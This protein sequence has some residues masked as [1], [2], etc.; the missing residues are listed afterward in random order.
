VADADSVIRVSI[1]GDA[2]NLSRAL[3]DASASIG[4]IA[5]GVVAG[6]VTL[7]T[8]EKGFDFLQDSEKE[9]ARLADA[10]K[11][12]DL[13]IGGVDERKIAAVA[14]SFHALGLS[15]QDVLEMSAN[16]AD[17]GVQAGIAKD[18]IAELAPEVAATAAAI[19]LLDDS[20]PAGNIDLIGKAAGGSAKAMKALGIS[21]SETDVVAR[22]MATGSHKLGDGLTD[23]E[24][25]TARLNFV[26]EALNPKLGA[27][28]DGSSD[29]E[30]S[31]RELTA[32]VKEL[33]GELGGPLS[34]ALNQVLRFILDEVRA[35]PGAVQGWESLGAAVEG[36]ART[37]VG[38][39]GNVADILRNINILLHQATGNA[40]GGINVGRLPGPSTRTSDNSVTRS[41]QRTT[42][43]NGG[44]GSSL[45]GP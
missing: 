18:R 22:A 24:I 8:I 44:I 28:T 43:R 36:F 25:K 17:F 10:I 35:I 45:G 3:K 1:I 26:L 32:T 4:G 7:R 11:R 39:L 16:F 14:G 21:V 31:Q 37:A 12:L 33:Q 30:K 13:S 2:K 9:A 42:A 41:I 34:D 23:A 29:L 19:S 40:G 20:D 27:A 38:P 6:L 5:K 15:S